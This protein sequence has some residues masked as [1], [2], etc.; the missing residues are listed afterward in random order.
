MSERASPASRAW[1][2]LIWTAAS[3]ILLVTLPAVAAAAAERDEPVRVAVY[4]FITP[5]GEETEQRRNEAALLSELAGLALGNIPGVNALERRRLGGMLREAALQ[6]ELG[7]E[8]EA[9]L[10]TSDVADL[11]VTGRLL[12]GVQR[13]LELSVTSV[14]TGVLLA[15]PTVPVPAGEPEAAIRAIQRHVMRAHRRHSPLDERADPLKR[16]AVGPFLPRRGSDR[17]HSVGVRIRGEI[18]RRLAQQGQ[19][20]IVARQPGYALFFE[21]YLA[22]VKDGALGSPGLPSSGLLIHGHYGATPDDGGDD[23]L[24]LVLKF[25]QFASEP[26]RPAMATVVVEAADARSLARAAARAISAHLRPPESPATLDEQ[27]TVERLMREAIQLGDVS[28]NPDA[29]RLQWPPF[30]RS[31][32]DDNVGQAQ[33]YRRWR[34][35]DHEHLGRAIA[36][37]Q[38]VLE[39]VPGHRQA[40]MLLAYLLKARDE[41]RANALWAAVVMEAPRS[42]AARAAGKQLNDQH[43]FRHAYPEPSIHDRL[44]DADL[45]EEWSIGVRPNLDGIA[46]GGTIYSAPEG[47]AP[48]RRA[49]LDWI[50]AEQAYRV[51]AQATRHVWGNDDESEVLTDIGQRLLGI[52]IRPKRFAW[53]PYNDP[54]Q[55]ESC[56]QQEHACWFR[57]DMSLVAITTLANL[58]ALHPDDHLSRLRLAKALDGSAHPF[59]GHAAWLYADAHRRTS[60]PFVRALASTLA[61]GP[62]LAGRASATSTSAEEPAASLAD[63]TVTFPSRERVTTSQARRIRDLATEPLRDA[64]ARGLDLLNANHG[65]VGPSVILD[66]I[67]FIADRFADG[68]RPLRTH[69][70]DGLRHRLEASPAA[71]IDRLVQ[72]GILD[73]YA[74]VKPALAAQGS[75]W[76]LEPEQWP[77]EWHRQTLNQVLFESTHADSVGVV[78][79]YTRAGEGW[80]RA[81]TLSASDAAARAQFGTDAASDGRL[82]MVCARGRGQRRS[83]NVGDAPPVP[84]GVYLFRRLNGRWV[85]TDK[86]LEGNCRNVDLSDR[87]VAATVDQ[88]VYLFER[89]NGNVLRQ[90]SVAPPDYAA[91]A[92][93]FEWFGADLAV[94]GDWLAVGNTSANQQT[95]DGD[96][97]SLWGT[98]D[99]FRFAEDEWRWHGRITGQPFADEARKFGDSVV[100]HDDSLWVGAP[101]SELHGLRNA[102]AVYR[103]RWNDGAWSMRERFI[104]SET[105]AD[106]RLGRKL[107]APG[108]GPM[109]SSRNSNEPWLFTLGE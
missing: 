103:F 22:R 46:K 51:S 32:L 100:F 28:D 9:A 58:V 43:V 29:T 55:F 30:T 50:E 34:K 68:R 37:V 87:W 56:G 85:E 41:H 26:R 15:A 82:L 90:R 47:T 75:A 54:P 64:Y 6:G 14:E 3:A 84:G 39:I 1:R 70:L 91:N 79:V 65:H 92:A 7:A 17:D 94:S 99:M 36:K 38:R 24:A 74:R 10:A 89:S 107:V 109:L 2:G 53:R 44:A 57:Q 8:A 93:Q 33:T 4:P 97:P 108:S 78:R 11:L 25:E 13:S 104:A 106:E 21:R 5:Q 72:Q 86:L 42:R 18:R 52:A 80:T 67:A 69:D 20:E 73:A 77:D 102:G 61:R 105:A 60:E 49:G 16:I 96:A 31:D 62:Q 88:R 83:R 63:P 98:V 59:A 12:G 40:R 76:Q 66:E 81:D 101:R 19:R 95:G 45:L 35:S 27:V 71:L 48:L 23:T